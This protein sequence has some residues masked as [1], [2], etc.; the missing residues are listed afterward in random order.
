MIWCRT[1][2]YHKVKFNS[3]IFDL[4]FCK[5]LP[6]FFQN[7]FFPR[8]FVFYSRV[9]IFN[10]I[11]NK[12]DFN[13]DDVN[14]NSFLNELGGSEINPTPIQ[15]TSEMVPIKIE[16]PLLSSSNASMNYSLTQA[17]TVSVPNHSLMTVNAMPQQQ[18]ASVNVAQLTS[19]EINAPVE[20]VVYQLANNPIVSTPFVTS[21]SPISQQQTII[22]N[23]TPVQMVFSNANA[24]KTVMQ[25]VQK[26][27]KIA[28]PKPITVKN[29]VVDN[30]GNSYILS[31]A[32]MYTGATTVASNSLQNIQLI[33]ASN[34][35]ILT[36]HVPVS[37]I[38]VDHES[39][40]TTSPV[41]KV[42]EVKRS[43][44][45][46]I[47]RRYRTSINDKI[48]ELKNMLVGEAGKLNKSAILKKSIDKIYDLENE[49][50]DLKM[51]NA[52]LRELLAQGTASND[53][54]LK[55]LLL[56][57][58]EN[59]H[60]RRITQ[61]STDNDRM[62]PPSSDESNPSLSPSHSD[63][64][65]MSP[66]GCDEISAEIN[67]YSEPSSRSK[68]SKK[69]STDSI[70]THGMSSLSKLT[71]CAF[72]FAFITFNPFASLLS[73]SNDPDMMLGEGELPSRR[74]L[75]V[76]SEI[77]FFQSLWLRFSDSFLVFALNLIVLIACLVKLC[78]HSDPIMNFR[79]PAADEYFKQKR[80][81]DAEF[82]SGNAGTAF[83]AY[84]KCLGMFGVTL[85][86][87]WYELIPL[88]I[89]QF[90]RCCVH[91]LRFGQWLSS[92]F[93]GIICSSETQKDALNS[94]QEL[95]KI[96]NRCNQIHLSQ[97]TRNGHGL[98]LSMYAVNMAETATNIDPLTLIDVYLTAA[99]RCRRNYA[100]F[101][102]WMCS[103]FYFYK[104]K[105][106]S[107][108]MYGRTLPPKYNWIFNNAYGYKF[109]CKFSF[110]ALE[111]NE[112]ENLFHEKVNPLDT[113]SL[114]FQV[115]SSFF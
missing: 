93:A 13:D 101:F 19:T 103:R 51:E 16:D 52:R 88:T 38:M 109:I 24:A 42:K 27:T 114:V 68:R 56:Q 4:Y 74:I 46:A 28:D 87:S 32:V 111:D 77:N 70:S 94:A 80:I 91:R 83:M 6:K 1:I 31:P 35:A 78:Y 11:I 65:S 57:K 33:D 12:F 5:L 50:Y 76:E 36:T 30:S 18:I 73:S 69:S 66:L 22:N 67:D 98:I 49:N 15:N 17:P 105:S 102:S 63:A 64:G 112:S 99:L 85:P 61:S 96:L 71:L 43:T 84:E 48:V 10:E 39:E 44:H 107:Q 7:V 25:P 47:E 79:S 92:K 72:M 45:N 100:Y 21:A 86:Q 81:A 3:I 41:P 58:P 8:V 90:L 97:N 106:A 82:E 59:H 2:F 34:G 75:G 9:D 37:T 14:I 40:K 62:T 54:T 55:H 115:N 110:D 95:A 29:S 23:L 20:T 104:A 53:S 108:A 26:Y 89:W 60:K 113:L